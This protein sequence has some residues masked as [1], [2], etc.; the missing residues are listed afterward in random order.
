ME[1]REEDCE[2]LGEQLIREMMYLELVFMGSCVGAVSRICVSFRGID[3]MLR[4]RRCRIG[5]TWGTVIGIGEL[6]TAES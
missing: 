3:E 6:Q 2:Y 4:T 5:S 1:L